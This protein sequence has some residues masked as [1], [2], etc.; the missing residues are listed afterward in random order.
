MKILKHGTL[1]ETKT[2]TSTCSHCHCH[3]EF[4]RAE[5]E[6]LSDQRDGDLLRVE[7][8]TCKRDVWTNH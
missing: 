5:A 3:M 4:T 1:P 8:P 2:Y 7:C 6:Y